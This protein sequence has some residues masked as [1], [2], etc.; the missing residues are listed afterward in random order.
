MRFAQ[1][2]W[3]VVGTFDAGSSGFDSEVWGD[4]EQAMQAFRRTAYSSVI[5]R[6]ADPDRFEALRRDIDADP[7]LTN[8]VKREQLFY[9]DQSRALSSFISILGLTLTTVFSTAAAS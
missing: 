3:T 1:R 5:V 6:L 7:R 4:V 2:D 8:E 9:A